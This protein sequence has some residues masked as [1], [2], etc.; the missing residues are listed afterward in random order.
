M[1]LGRVLFDTAVFVYAV[2]TEHPY[3]EPCRLLLNPD[4]TSGMSV[5]AI[6]ELLH[7]RARRT[8]NRA[9][10]VEVADAMA[11]LC[12]FH[13]LT[14]RDL[15]LG[16]HRTAPLMRFRVFAGWTRCRLFPS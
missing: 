14:E 16:H 4:R 8:G 11:S 7:Q 15:R 3:R 2:G 5:Q 12:Q 10:A 6:Q 1:S 13:H 9:E